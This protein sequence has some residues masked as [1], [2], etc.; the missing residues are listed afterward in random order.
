MHATR[1]AVFQDG[2]SPFLAQRD[3]EM[4]TETSGLCDVGYSDLYRVRCSE[5]KYGLNNYNNIAL[6]QR[7]G[8]SRRILQ[9]N[10]PQDAAL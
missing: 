3:C 5:T 10:V 1:C 8:V 7:L 9:E 6:D 4:I 2:Q